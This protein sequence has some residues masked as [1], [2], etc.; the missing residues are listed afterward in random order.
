MITQ[1]KED[2]AIN[3]RIAKRLGTWNFGD[4]TQPS[5]VV[6]RHSMAR[7]LTAVRIESPK[8]T[9]LNWEQLIK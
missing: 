6:Q 1:T 3:Q 4:R 8:V 2:Q 7:G 5:Y 9:C